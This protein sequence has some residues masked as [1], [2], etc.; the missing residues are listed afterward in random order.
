M[1]VA[2]TA[3]INQVFG[4]PDRDR[5]AGE[6]S[7]T[8]IEFDKQIQE[9][10]PVALTKPWARATC[11]LLLQADGYLADRKLQQGW[12]ALKSAQRAMLTNPN[13]K[14][15]ISRAAIVLRREVESEKF[16]AWRS[17]AIKDLIG[18]P[19]AEPE[20]KR[21]IEAL[22]L[23]DDQNNTTYFKIALR[24]R[25]LF[26]L[27]WLLLLFIGLCLLLS[28][29]GKMPEPFNEPMKVTTVLLF[30]ALGAI[31]SVSQGLLAT[32]ASAKIPAQQIGS[33]AV[34]MRPPIGAT[35]ALVALIV[36]Y[37]N[38]KFEIFQNKWD[39]KHLGV[40]LAFA[41]IAGFSERFVVGAIERI[42]GAADTNGDAKK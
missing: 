20:P 17:H 25:H 28:F 31:V 9:D 33:V 14:D 24:R 27:F 4:S 32:N 40:I 38:E 35:L 42:A 26:Q 3:L 16:S 22:S 36:L 29:L 30:G 5:L 10:S 8:W 6:I 19:G 34:W 7:E 12:V 1:I 11:R 15:R 2:R 21:V 18:E 13:D 23:R 39:W 41:F 37:G